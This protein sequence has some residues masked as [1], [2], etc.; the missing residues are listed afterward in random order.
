MI[1]PSSEYGA[2]RHD[3]PLCP[4]FLAVDRRVAVK[5]VCCICVVAA[6]LAWLVGMT[7]CE[8]GPSPSGPSAQGTRIPTQ[9]LVQQLKTSQD[10]NA[11]MH[12]ARDLGKIPPDELKGV[13]KDLK[14]AL[15]AELDNGV[16]VEI[17]D[18]LKK[19]KYL[20]KAK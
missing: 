10:A 2:Q 1:Q 4:V 19:A 3:A 15:A 18:T 14:E 5:S 11:R 12:A 13:V 20:K 16:K 17:E 7:A 6:G 8:R 9:E